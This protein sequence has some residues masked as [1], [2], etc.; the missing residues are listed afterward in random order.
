M[1]RLLFIGLLSFFPALGFAQAGLST[2]PLKLYYTFPPGGQR[3]QTVTVMNPTNR[4]VDVGVS[5][6]GWK[7]SKAGENEIVTRGSLLTSCADWIKVLPSSY[8]VLP[9]HGRKQV[10]VVLSVPADADTSEP[11]RTSL[12]LFSQLNPTRGKTN[13]R[14]VV[15][16][17]TVRV[18]VKIYYT[19]Y[20]NAAPNIEVK[21]FDTFINKGGIT[22]VV[23][24][25]KNIGKIWADGNVSWE[26]FNQNSGKKQKLGKTRFYTLPGDLRQIKKALPGDLEPGSYKL[27]AIV[28]FGNRNVIK[29]AEL[30]FKL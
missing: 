27:T 29:V 17:E 4:E 14:G 12:L 6:D 13:A 24:N 8:F 7:Y 2:S 23:L 28:K 20:P 30:S 9:P 1:G 21:D 11:V 5:F 25:L 15:I 10:K 19:F 22:A 3:M 16:R 26:L 18:G